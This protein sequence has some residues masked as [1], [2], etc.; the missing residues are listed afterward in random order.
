V[1]EETAEFDLKEMEKAGYRI[2]DVK[3]VAWCGGLFF[4]NAKET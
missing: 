4:Y 1:D 2:W 3:P